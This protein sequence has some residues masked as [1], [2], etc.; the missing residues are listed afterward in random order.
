MVIPTGYPVAV[1][2]FVIVT[3]GST[4]SVAVGTP[5]DTIVSIPVASAVILLQVQH[6]L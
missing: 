6:Y 3:V 2:L 4:I 1:P 5:R